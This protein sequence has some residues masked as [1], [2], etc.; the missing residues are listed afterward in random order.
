MHLSKTLALIVSL[1]CASAT[2]SENAR[3]QPAGTKAD[4]G[5]KNDAKRRDRPLTHSLAD[6]DHVILLMQENRAFDHYFGTMAGVRGFSDPNV[7]I[8]PLL[9]PLSDNGATMSHW[10]LNYDGD[11]NNL[12]S[13]CIDTVNP[14]WQDNRNSYNHGLNNMWALSQSPHSIGYFK[15]KDIPTQFALA[16]NFVVADMYQSSIFSSTSPNRV[17]WASGSSNIPGSPQ[18]KDQ[19]GFPYIDNWEPAGGGCKDDGSSCF[20]LKWKTA[21]E[22]YEDA[23]VDW[24]VF[25]DPNDNF[26][27]NPWYW[28]EQFRRGGPLQSK[29]AQG[30]S[31]DS[32]Y[33][34]LRTG[35]LPEISI[36][37]PGASLSEHSGIGLPMDGGGLQDKIARAVLN[38]PAYPRTALIVSYD[39]G[40]GWY[41]HVPIF[42]SPRGTPGEWLEDPLDNTGYTFAGPGIRVPMYIISPWTRNGGVYTEHADHT[43]QLQFIEKWQAAK[44]RNVVTDQMVQWRRDNMADLVSAFNFDKPDYSK[45][46]LPTAPPYKGYGACPSRS[47][48]TPPGYKG[49]NQ[50]T[51]KRSAPSYHMER[52]WKPVRGKLT[53][54][55]HLAMVMNDHALTHAHPNKR[56]GNIHATRAVEN[57]DEPTQHWVIS[58]EVIG[59]DEFTVMAWNDGRHICHESEM[60]GDRGNATIFTVGFEPGQGHTLWSKSMGK[61]M[62][63]DEEGQIDYSDTASHWDIFSVSY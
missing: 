22:F 31:W 23:G 6:I 16:K 5:H 11:G 44:G 38:S 45:P 52:G 56:N 63:V 43:S 33:D 2:I 13:H 58:A 20:P 25:Q 9:S 27:D 18:N 32:F 29:A 60:C 48:P 59:G 17:F 39:E 54:G 51:S 61:Y 10:Y 62:L 24:M 12:L 1:R 7:N 26:D 57:H 19:G 15:E 40:G 37:V 3:G 42:H 28:F 30:E 14:S 36:V 55:R 47:G 49:Y 50:R 35:N 46:D 21:V 34:R 53:E 4:E 8:N 41:D